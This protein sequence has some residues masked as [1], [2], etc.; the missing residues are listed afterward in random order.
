V[1]HTNVDRATGGT[2]QTV[3]RGGGVIDVVHVAV[4]GVGILT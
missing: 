4:G 1:V 3:I 2:D